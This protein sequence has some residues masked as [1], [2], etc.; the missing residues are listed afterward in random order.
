[1]PA[2]A[3]RQAGSVAPYDRAVLQL[4]AGRW[5]W[6]APH[7]D[8][9]PAAHW[10]R[11]VSSHAIDDGTRLL[12]FDPLAVPQAL[13]EL[14]TERTPVIVLTAPWHERDTRTL[15]E[16]LDS[17]V[18]TPAPDTA[19]DLV[20]KY[21]ITLEQ[22]GTG[23]PDFAWLVTG[24][25]APADAH[26]Y[27]AGDRLP[28]GIEVFP[29]RAHNDLV[30]WIESRRVVIAGDTLADYGRGLQIPP[31]ALTREATREQVAHGLRPLLQLPVE[32]V[33]PAHGPPTDRGA[34]ERA[35]A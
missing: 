30:L 10:P 29:G 12:L 32:L 15:S 1:M 2:A 19:E 11:L 7:P 14:A 23:S 27:A 20:R 8:W 13:L 28:V 24:Q 18:F 22:A 4:I 3:A 25:R 35:L 21:G 5:H 34:L 26:M 9:S 6:R 16:S 33:L 17:P 31:Q